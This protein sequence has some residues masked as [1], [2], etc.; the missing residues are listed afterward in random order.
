MCACPYNTKAAVLVAVEQDIR[1]AIVH[2][3]HQQAIAGCGMRPAVFI[4]V[5]H[6][7]AMAFGAL[8]EAAV[9]VG[10]PSA[11]ILYAI[12]IVVVMHH[13]VKQ[14]SCHFFDRTG[15]RSCADVDFMCRTVFGKPCVTSQ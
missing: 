2:N 12:F 3:K 15:K 4:A 14:R 7:K 9:V 8:L 6:T 5:R 1:Q 10:V 11:A 13:L